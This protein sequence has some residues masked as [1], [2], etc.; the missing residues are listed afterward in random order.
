MGV[1]FS[2]GVMYKDKC[3]GRPL[4]PIYL[5]V[6][7]TSYLLTILLLP[8]KRCC[9]QLCAVLEGFL[10]IFIICWLITGSFWVFSIYLVYP[11]FCDTVLYQFS[12]GILIFQYIYVVIV[13]V[14]LVF[15]ICFVGFKSLTK[16]SLI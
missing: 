6:A 14:T 9:R 5:I 12:F 3:P 10:L 1:T 8:L 11:L 4:I 7:G 13:S 16:A 2:G 15:V